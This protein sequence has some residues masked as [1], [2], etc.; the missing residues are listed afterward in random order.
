MVGA[1]NQHEFVFRAAL[2]VES[3]V[4]DV[5]AYF[6]LAYYLV[7]HSYR[8]SHSRG[9]CKVVAVVVRNRSPRR[10][11]AASGVVGKASD[12][13]AGGVHRVYLKIPVP[14]G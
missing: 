12:A 8:Y 9:G 14:V 2:G 7:K 3:E 10:G 6:N 1:R 5:A 4:V 13:G 11:E